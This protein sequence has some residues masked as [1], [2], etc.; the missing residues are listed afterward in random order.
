MT[1]VFLL[2]LYSRNNI[3]ETFVGPIISDGEAVRIESWI[4][5]AVDAGA[6]LLVGGKREGGHICT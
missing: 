3:E 5:E 2:S 6:T 1:R 4:K